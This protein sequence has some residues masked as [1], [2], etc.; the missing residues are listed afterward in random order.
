MKKSAFALVVVC[1]IASACATVQMAPKNYPQPPSALFSTML[2]TLQ[3][4]GY[5]IKTAEK[6]AGLILAEKTRAI[7][8]LNQA[9]NGVRSRAY[10]VSIT[11]VGQDGGTRYSITV[12]N[13]NMGVQGNWPQKTA[14]EITANF[15]AK[16]K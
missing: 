7:D 5:I 9:M 2:I 12:N 11:F 1:L 8:G 14:E 15:E 4:M 6:D 16:I 10:Q 13:P 3:E